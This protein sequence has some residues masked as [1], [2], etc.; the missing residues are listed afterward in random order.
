M[1][2]CILTT[3]VCSESKADKTPAQSADSNNRSKKNSA[4]MQN[5]IHEAFELLNSFSGGSGTGF[6]N[7]FTKTSEIARGLNNPTVISA[8][9][10]A[11][12][13]LFSTFRKVSKD[14]VKDPAKR[15]TWTSREFDGFL[16]E[17]KTQFINSIKEKPGISSS[18]VSQIEFGAS[19][20]LSG[21]VEMYDGLV[22]GIGI[23]LNNGLILSVADMSSLLE[24]ERYVD[25]STF[26]GL[27]SFPEEMMNN[28]ESLITQ[29][30]TPDQLRM[31]IM[32]LKMYSSNNKRREH[33]E[34]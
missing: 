2:L 20:L 21:L 14:F 7:M 13:S 28:L 30:A 10:G 6:L 27:A 17:F 15:D 18:T 3:F 26:S 19:E 31:G 16:K 32:M 1:L 24:R 33:E 25:S 34:L 9:N 8:I 4:E 12:K 23:G 5:L 11:I 22:S 29:F